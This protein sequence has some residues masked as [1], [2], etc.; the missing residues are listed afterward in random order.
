M[1]TISW[2][3][4]IA[5]TIQ[6]P[7]EY[8]T[9]KVKKHG[10]S[11]FLLPHCCTP[12]WVTDPACYVLRRRKISDAWDE[13][14]NVLKC[15]NYQ[16]T[17]Q[18]AFQKWLINTLKPIPG[19]NIIEGG[20]GIAEL[21]GLYV[22]TAYDVARTVPDTIK[23]GLNDLAA[24]GSFIFTNKD[25]DNARWL[26]ASHELAK[27]LWPGTYDQEFT[28]ITY[29]NL[30]IIKD[31]FLETPYC[32]MLS[33]WAHELVHV[34]QYNLLGWENFLSL[35]I[36]SSA[37]LTY[38]GTPIEKIAYEVDRRVFSRCQS[39]PANLININHDKRNRIENLISDL[40]SRGEIYLDQD[41]E[42]IHISSGAEG[43]I[44]LIIDKT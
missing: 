3:E 8:V 25:L 2:C 18:E 40:S 17:A 33:T 6:H 11:C 36:T 19:F 43:E 20:P 21:L 32:N 31:S 37:V 1:P 10:V 24:D 7:A 12:A 42:I 5:L 34:H 9:E 27:P 16:L 35:Y 30:I 14:K 26:P 38:E 4:E 23:P 13:I 15:E 29:Y 28:A 44:K 41:G 39:N 22:A